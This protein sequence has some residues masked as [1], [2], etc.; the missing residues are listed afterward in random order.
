MGD[1][2][3][4]PYLD[5]V[6]SDSPRTLVDEVERHLRALLRDVMCGYLDADLRSV[7]DGLLLAPPEPFEIQASDLR[8]QTSGLRPQ[9]S[10]ARAPAAVVA[11]ST[12]DSRSHRRQTTDR[13]P[14]SPTPDSTTSR[15][16]RRPRFSFSAPVSESTSRLSG[17]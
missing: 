14:P 3:E 4:D 7:A 11:R 13:R 16:R 17:R 9:T 5:A 10:E 15:L 12:V 2:R 6:G 1:G 8:P